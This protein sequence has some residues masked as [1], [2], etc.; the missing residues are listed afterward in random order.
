MSFKFSDDGPAFPSALLNQMIAGEVVFLCGAGVSRPQLP[1]F[2]DLVQ[3]VFKDLGI[4]MDAGEL[5]AFEHD[6]YEESLGSLAR[7]VVHPSKMYQAVE[8]HLTT[9]KTPDLSRHQTLIRLSRT[10]DNRICLVTTNFDTLF[11]RAAL[12]SEEVAQAGPISIAGQSLPAPG[13]EDFAGIVHL[14]G[15]LPDAH[16]K[17]ERSPLVLTSAEYG[18]AYMRSGWASRFLFDLA[19]CKTIVLVGYRAGDAPVRYFLNV[20]EADREHFPD[21]RNVYTLEGVDGLEGDADARWST[22]A[23]H[24]ITYPKEVPGLEQHEVLWRDLRSLADMLERPKVQRRERACDI[25]AKAVTEASAEDLDRIDWIMRGRGDL[26]D[27]VLSHVED[28]AWFE[29]FSTRGLWGETDPDR[30]LPAWFKTRWESQ[31]A[32]DVAVEWCAKDRMNLLIGADQQLHQP[33]RPSAPWYRPWKLLISANLHRLNLRRVDRFRFAMQMRDGGAIDLDLRCAV[34]LLTPTLAIKKPYVHSGEQRPEEPFELRHFYSV[35][36]TVGENGAEELLEALLQHKAMNS[37]LL[38]LTNEALRSTICLAVDAELITANWDELENRL[39]SVDDHRQNQNVD[40]VL[41]LVRLATRL[42]GELAA[43]EPLLARGAA[44]EWKALHSKLGT[45]LWLHALRRSEVFSTEE[46]IDEVEALP[47]DR[48]WAQQP[49]LFAL[50]TARFGEATQTQIDRITQ[51]ILREGPTLFEDLVRVA[52]STDWRP[53]ARAHAIWLSLRSIQEVSSLSTEAKSELECIIRTHP[54]LNRSVEVQDYFS[55][56]ISGVRSISGNPV[57]LLEAEP[58]ERLELA[59][60][61]NTSGDFDTNANWRAYTQTDPRRAFEVIAKNG[62]RPADLDLWIDLVNTLNFPVPTDEA[63]LEE[64]RRLLAKIL[65]ALDHAYDDDIQRLVHPLSISINISGVLSTKAYSRWWDRLWN[66]AVTTENPDDR[67]DNSD[68]FY[69]WVINTTSGKLTETLLR[70]ID[71]QRKTT[72]RIGTANMNRLRRISREPSVAGKLGR[73]ALTQAIGFLVHISESFVRNQMVPVLLENSI[74]GAR[75]RGIIAGYS[76]LGAHAS[77]VLKDVLLM[78]A[79]ELRA[80]GGYQA[81]NTVAKILTPLLATRAEPS[82]AD[83][84]LTAPE[85]RNALAKGSTALRVAAA[86]VLSIWQRQIGE[87]KPEETWRRIVGPTFQEIWPLERC[88]KHPQITNHLAHICVSAG[89]EF[90]N[91]LAVLHPYFSSDGENIELF[92]LFNSE[93]PTKFPEATLELLW[94][95][96]R[97]RKD[98]YGS[99][100]LAGALDKIKAALPKLEVDRRF[101]A[102]EARTLR[103]A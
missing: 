15:R 34:D 35:N 20:L 82:T 90:P 71:R 103:F 91:A 17:L 102:L 85:V 10:L 21:L 25:L 36:L 98:E 92:F 93:V 14:H 95:V 32:L 12:Q 61:F 100:E 64:R 22:V 89:E 94:L 39:P 70:V 5:D 16:A 79:G 30:L 68:R 80:D 19:R 63:K 24:P 67:R 51:R 27:I 72:G 87:R 101:Q 44:D 66:L 97:K 96:L 40:G 86:R 56:Y 62:F 83:W 76:R 55:F 59:H 43:S 52:G 4:A 50:I 48:F 1:G 3:E 26:W 33:L 49:E 7:R 9:P 77:R 13:A 57:P 8:R 37:R 65:K 69:D 99:L 78:A 84:G 47:L 88:Y 54:H 42:Y 38:Q 11:E 29:H 2:A 58:E 23:V 46:V 60:Q 45:R 41:H 53:Y 31:R 75:L 28:P 81:G 74:E 73:G 18:D 6:R